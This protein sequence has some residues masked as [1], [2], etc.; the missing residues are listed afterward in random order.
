MYGMALSLLAAF[1]SSNETEAKRVAES[2]PNLGRS[3]VASV[4][5]VASFSSASSSESWLSDGMIGG[6]SSRL[7]M[8]SIM[9]CAGDRLLRRKMLSRSGMRA[10]L[11]VVLWLVVSTDMS[12]ETDRERP[13]WKRE[14][15]I[16][17]S[18]SSSSSSRRSTLNCVLGARA[19][20][21]GAPYC[22]AMSKLSR[23]GVILRM[24]CRPLTSSLALL[25][26]SLLLLSRDPKLGREAVSEMY[27]SW[28]PKWLLVA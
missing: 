26:S 2:W 1:S 14:T 8:L 15:T 22:S 16:E 12:S 25:W 19:A 20:E 9:T 11:A 13:A 7:L 6:R 4:E 28:L 27:T 5:A 17:E 18:S 10:T 23:R 24:A 21:V 3:M